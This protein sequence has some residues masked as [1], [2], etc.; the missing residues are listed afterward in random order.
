MSNMKCKDSSEEEEINVLAS[1]DIKTSSSERK[2]SM[3]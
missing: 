1:L 2:N 3:L